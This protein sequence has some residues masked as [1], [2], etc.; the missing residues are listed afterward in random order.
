MHPPPPVANQKPP[1]H[2]TPGLT[3]G[4]LTDF[5]TQ[6]GYV[7]TMK[8]ALLSCLSFSNTLPLH[9][10]DIGHEVPPHDIA[11]G[12][13]LLN[14]V[15]DYLPPLTVCV[16]VVDPHV[17]QPEQNSLCVVWPQRQ[18]IFLAPDNGLLSPVLQHAAFQ[19]D[20]SLQHLPEEEP[21]NNTPHCIRLT[22]PLR[23]DDDESTHR[24]TSLTQPALAALP[25]HTFYGRD[26]YAPVAAHWINALNQNPSLCHSPK[27]L[28]DFLRQLGTPHPQPKQTARLL[29]QQT[30]QGI[31]GHGLYSDRF[32]NLLTNIP[33]HWIDGDF[34]PIQLQ[35]GTTPG[36]CWPGY[37]AASYYQALTQVPNTV[38]PDPQANPPSPLLLVAG[39]N[40]YLELALYQSSATH[41]L[42]Q[43]LNLP[44]LPR[45]LALT[46]RQ[47]AAP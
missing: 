5:G 34:R 30:A 47:D 41:W 18:C 43:V 20:W 9:W 12:S 2:Y 19:Q 4:L 27:Q 14:N 3:V 45:P 22:P 39:S 28:K 8:A 11:A 32:G 25:S 16:C 31:Q 17:G 36:A 42:R 6:D 24:T 26:L 10:L 38:G 1:A 35:I 33:N 15:L 21:Q 46:I 40:G 7:G 29:A 13:W 37:K 44:H 23:I